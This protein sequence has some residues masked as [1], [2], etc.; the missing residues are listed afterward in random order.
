[1]EEGFDGQNVSDL[2]VRRMIQRAIAGDLGFVKEVLDRYCGKVP[3]RLTG[4]DGDGPVK[5]VYV[6]K[7]DQI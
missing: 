1:M 3:L 5:V 4:G 7:P 6:S 2:I